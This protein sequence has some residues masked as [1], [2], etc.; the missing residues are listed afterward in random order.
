MFLGNT[1][2]VYILDK[3]EG[4]AAL[5]NGHPAW[6]A[7]WSVSLQRFI[8]FPHS[9][10]FDPRDIATQKATTMDVATNVFCSSG[11]HLPNG[12]YV[13]FGGNTAVGR[14]GSSGSQIG[15]TGIP[16]W[17]AEYQDFD[18]SKSIRIL[19]PCS[20]SDN[21]ADASCQWYDDPSVISMQKRR[22]YSTAEALADGSIVLI[23][24]F[25]NGGYINRNS[26]PTNADPTYEGGAAEPT[27]EFF[28]ANGRAPQLMQ[29]MTT[30][31]GLNAYAHAFLLNSGKMFVQAN[32]STSPFPFFLS[33]L[34]LS[35]RPLPQSSG[36]TTPTLKHPFR[37]CQARSSESIPPLAPS[38]C[39]P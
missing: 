13:T 22:W 19:N 25:V 20:S 4:N 35:D 36:T 3:A 16:A 38:P 24:G 27:Y 29:F 9:E 10:R 17:D 6:G 31:S 26:Y 37:I 39:F 14:G 34:S 30:T 7:V 32:F 23:G 18:G 21:F 28:P 2:K 11:M 33:F 5:V 1:E 15:P 8:L 12:S